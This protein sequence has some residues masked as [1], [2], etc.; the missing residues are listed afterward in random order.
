MST[1]AEIF[2][3]MPSRFNPAGAPGWE[4]TIQ[5]NLSGEGGG[6]WTLTVK[7]GVCEVKEGKAEAP[8]ATLET[9]A[10]TWVGVHAGKLNAMQA[11]MSGKI[12]ASGNVTEL[13]KLNNP[14]VFKRQ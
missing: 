1:P 10:Q 14:M 3:N 12:K 2:Q 4:T 5:F 13:M 7:G 9:D 6:Q 8:K 11:F